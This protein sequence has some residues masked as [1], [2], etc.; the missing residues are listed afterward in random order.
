MVVEC[1]APIDTT[2][3]QIPHLRLKE[4]RR[5]EW[6]D[7]KKPEDQ[8]SCC[9]IMSSRNTYEAAPMKSQKYCHLRET[10]IMMAPVEPTLVQSIS[11]ETES[12]LTAELC[13]PDDRNR[14][15]GN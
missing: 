11:S 4:Y 1:S 5:D 6:E 13:G 8:A 2:I 9:K 7:C 10:Y 3:I 15:W 12:G 14:V